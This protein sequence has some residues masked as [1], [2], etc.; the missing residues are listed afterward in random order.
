MLQERHYRT[1]GPC[2][3]CC[4]EAAVREKVHAGICERWWLMP[5]RLKG[6]VQLTAFHLCAPVRL[7]VNKLISKA[8]DKG[9]TLKRL[10]PAIQGRFPQQVQN[11]LKPRHRYRSSRGKRLAHKHRLRGLQSRERQRTA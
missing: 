10:G 4:A 7:V 3:T 6:R 11:E 9:S 1:K 5:Q 2:A 8:N